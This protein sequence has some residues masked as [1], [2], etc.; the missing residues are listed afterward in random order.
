M[1]YLELKGGRERVFDF[2][3]S[4]AVLA[5][6]HTSYTPRAA[7]PR[8][9]APRLSAEEAAAHTIF[10]SELGEAAIWKKFA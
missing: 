8:P 9:L 1:A 6:A 10:V 5:A 3:S 4:N 2:A 7:R